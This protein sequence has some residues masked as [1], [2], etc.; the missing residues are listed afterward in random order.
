MRTSGERK[1]E[2]VGKGRIT[3]AETSLPI[4]FSFS[5][6]RSIFPSGATEASCEMNEKQSVGRR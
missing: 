3:D 2:K 1:G 6:T 5:P 4:A